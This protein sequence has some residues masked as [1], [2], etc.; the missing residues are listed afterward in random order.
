MHSLVLIP[1]ISLITLNTQLDNA[2]GDVVVSSGA[3][4]CVGAFTSEYRG[5][6]WW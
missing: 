2:T 5:V 6:R 3:I 1:Y 4:A